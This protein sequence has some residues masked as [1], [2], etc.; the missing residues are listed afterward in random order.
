MKAHKNNTK[1]F[2]KLNFKE[3]TNSINAQIINLESAI[4]SHL[5]LS[6]IEV[7]NTNE[8]KQSIKE[9]IKR[10]IDRL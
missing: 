1:N 4:V 5:K 3:Q 7:R 2:D 6:E 10:M 9:Q 8:I